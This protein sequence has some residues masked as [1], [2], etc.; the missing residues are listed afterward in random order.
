M[1]FH[2]NIWRQPGPGKKGRFESYEL[3]GISPDAS[4]LEMIDILN[5]RLIEADREPVAF[6]HDCREGICGAC[7]CVVD[8]YAHGHQKGTTLC[9]LHMRSFKDQ[10]MVFIQVSFVRDICHFWL[11]FIYDS[12]NRIVQLFLGYGV[13]LDGREIQEESLLNIQDLIRP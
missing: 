7:G 13:K 2:L 6:D 11:Y 9:Q 10:A 5:E 4:F 12:G 8:G 1:D 3:K